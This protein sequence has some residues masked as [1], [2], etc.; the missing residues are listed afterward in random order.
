MWSLAQV[1]H[2]FESRV[3]SCV[4]ALMLEAYLASCGLEVSDI[5][6]VTGA[7]VTAK[8]GTLVAWMVVG[9][10]YQPMRR[11]FLARHRVLGIRNTVRPWAQRQAKMAYVRRVSHTLSVAKSGVAHAR[12]RLRERLRLRRPDT[13]LSPKN[14]W[15]AWASAKYWTLFDKLEKSASRSRLWKYFAGVLQV[16]PKNAMGVAEGF[17]LYKVTFLLIAPLELW[18]I[19]KYFKR[20]HVVASRPS[21]GDDGTES[22]PSVPESVTSCCVP[23]ASSEIQ[24]PGGETGDFVRTPT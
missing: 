13:R 17:L 22:V 23:G 4:C 3:V 10:R 20:K 18:L 1:P 16:D 24:Y 2:V 11:M 8:Y 14:S 21:E 12:E 15:H 19:V 6:K 5:P 9:A 7:L